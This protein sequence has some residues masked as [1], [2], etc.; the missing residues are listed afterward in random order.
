MQPTPSTPSP[1]RFEAH[2]SRRRRP[3][4]RPTAAGFPASIAAEAT[5]VLDPE[6]VDLAERLREAELRLAIESA[7]SRILRFA[8]ARG[9][10]T[11]TPAIREEDA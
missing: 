10:R 5:A 4:A 7:V 9:A 1:V 3:W 2:R 8:L 11:S 6:N